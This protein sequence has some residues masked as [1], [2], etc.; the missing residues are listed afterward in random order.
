MTTIVG[1]DP[2]AHG[3]IGMIQPDVCVWDMPATPHDLATLLRTFDP[4]TTRVY[5]EAVHSMPGQGVSSTFKFG[6]GFGEILG[7][8]AALDIPH[9]MVAPA[10]WKTAM[11]LRGAEKAASKRLAQQLYGRVASNEGKSEALLI[12]TWGAK[13]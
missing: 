7:V 8:L 12:A 9:T 13:R 1:I 6:K 3:A 5:V 11:G 4:R 2:G 10:T